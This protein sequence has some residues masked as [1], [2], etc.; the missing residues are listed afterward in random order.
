M[1]KIIFIVGPTAVG[2]TEI[3]LVLAKKIGGE[4]VSCDSMQVYREV[5]I[6][7]GKP[8]AGTL[9]KIPHH[10]IDIISVQKEYDVASFNRRALKAVG[11]IHSRGKIPIVVGGSGLYMQVLLDGIFEGGT[12]KKE[13][14][15]ELEARAKKEGSEVL[16]RELLKTDAEAAKKIHPHDARRIIRAL[17]VYAVSKKP[18]SDLQKTRSGLWGKN[19]IMIFA[20]N[21]DRPELYKRIDGRVEQMFREGVVEEVRGLMKRRL[22]RTARNLIGI[23]EI[24]GFLKGEHDLERAKYLMKLNTR[25]FAKRQLTWF[26][27]DKRLNW[28]TII[29]SQSMREVAREIWAQL[30][31]KGFLEQAQ[32]PTKGMFDG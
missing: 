21:R 4:I 15:A 13:F 22:S 29:S 19:D 27:K 31:E 6:A 30:K 25:H 11:V 3:S 8:S 9:K 17:E 5:N 23:N 1:N 26:R 18:I 2:K 14:R 12:S 16:F 32:R 10:L 28:L 20:L 24:G 7:S